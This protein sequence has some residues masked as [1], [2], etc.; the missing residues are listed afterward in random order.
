MQKK[1]QKIA[2][3]EEK[4]EG[5]ECGKKAENIW[6]AAHTYSLQSPSSLFEYP[7]LVYKNEKLYKMEFI[8]S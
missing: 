2:K 7:H 4:K 1:L 6:P 3:K 5:V 8:H